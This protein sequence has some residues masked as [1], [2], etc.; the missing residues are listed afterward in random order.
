MLKSFLK[1][2]ED[3]HKQNEP[4]YTVELATA[5]LLSEIVNADNQVTETEREEYE[6]QLRKHVNVD[7]DAMALLLKR[8]Q[9]TADD[10]VDLVHFTQVLNKHCNADERVRVVKSLWSIAYADESLAPLEESTIRQ[11]A[12]LLY[13]PHSQYIK[14]K[15]EVVENTQ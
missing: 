2:F 4:A 9:E 13:V 11:I 15:L 1:L 14:T 5:A 8:G 12:D 3:S 7:D 6:K 10:A